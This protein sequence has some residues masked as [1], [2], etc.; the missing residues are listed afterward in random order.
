MEQKKLRMALLLRSDKVPSWKYAAIEEVLKSDIAE[1]TFIGKFQHVEA[2]KNHTTS[3]LYK[4]Y[5]RLEKL[6][7]K[8]PASASEEREISSLFTQK[9]DPVEVKLDRDQGVYRLTQA[10]SHP[11]IAAKLDVIYLLDYIPLKL[12]L[13]TLATYGVWYHHFGL[14]GSDF[15]SFTGF[16]EFLNGS[17]FIISSLRGFQNDCRH[18]EVYYESKGP[19]D[20]FSIG[21]TREWCFWKSARFVKRKLTEVYLKEELLPVKL[22]ASDGQPNPDGALN[23]VDLF[24]VN[25]TFIKRYLKEKIINRYYSERWGLLFHKNQQ[26]FLSLKDLKTLLPPKNKFWADPFIYSENGQYFIFL[27]ESYLGKKKKGFISVMEI[28]A[29]GQISETRKVIEQPY[30]L[31]YPFVF[32]WE[33]KQYMIPESN[34]NRTIQLYECKE[35]PYRWEFV[36]NLRENIS[37][38]DTTLFFHNNKWWIFANIKEHQHASLWDELFLFFT[39]DPLSSEWTPHPQN[40][41]VSDVTKARPAG[42]VFKIGHR[43]FR[44]AQNCSYRYGY[45][46]TIMEIVNLTENSYEEKEEISYTPNDLEKINGLHSYNKLDEFTVID[47]VIRS[48][49][50]F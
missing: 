35:F 24:N 45:G 6:K 32:R 44:P 29:E 43:I 13:S 14:A 8:G 19:I 34:Q 27:E 12:E 36:K 26:N 50:I 48:R 3:F 16:R 31:S 5:Q 46:L 18:E 40:P 20:R 9:Y 38:V 41:I 28:N 22:P 21:R 1:I 10:N 39:D 30:H 33:G 49:K 15:E 25:L 11:L 37:A 4:I 17:P 42:Q 7:W 2:N 23:F 47:A